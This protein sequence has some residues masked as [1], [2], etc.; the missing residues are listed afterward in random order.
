MDETNVG[1]RVCVRVRL[2]SWAPPTGQNTLEF[3]AE[4]KFSSRV[5]V[6]ARACACVRLR[7]PK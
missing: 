6:R 3:V 5:R 4:M 2:H 1:V 7:H